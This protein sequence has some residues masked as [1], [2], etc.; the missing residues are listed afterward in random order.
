MLVFIA[1]AAR[2]K[3]ISVTEIISYPDKPTSS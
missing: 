1:Y 3:S 2:L